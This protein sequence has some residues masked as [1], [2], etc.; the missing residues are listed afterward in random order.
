M[1]G[2]AGDDPL[3]AAPGITAGWSRAAGVPLDY[4]SPLSDDYWLY[5]TG[6]AGFPYP[7]DVLERLQ[8]RPDI[9]AGH[10]HSVA[11]S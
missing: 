6:R 9:R 8:G 11:R 2:H 1:S 10:A 4:M 5:R 3:R 7:D